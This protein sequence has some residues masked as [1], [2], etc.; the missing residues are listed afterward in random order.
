LISRVV[1]SRSDPAQT[2][3]PDRSL[4]GAAEARTTVRPRD[5]KHETP[6]PT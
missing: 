1:P 4:D 5:Q 2:A 6:D 3:Q